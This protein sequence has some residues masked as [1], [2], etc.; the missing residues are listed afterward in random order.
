MACLL[1][2]W[3]AKRGGRSLFKTSRVTSWREGFSAL[4]GRAVWGGHDSVEQCNARS[5]TLFRERNRCALGGSALTES[6]RRRAQQLASLLLSF[7]ELSSQ[8]PPSTY[9]SSLPSRSFP[10]HLKAHLSSQPK[11]LCTIC[12]S[13]PSPSPIPRPSASSQNPTLRAPFHLHLLPPISAK[14][15]PTSTP[16]PTSPR[17]DPPPKQDVTSPKPATMNL[18][19]A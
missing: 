18:P 4:D 17:S 2:L 13:S 5:F 8:L 10:E 9:L 6:D 7:F 11:S 16:L 3:L 14:P 15:I 12:S 19:G 1:A